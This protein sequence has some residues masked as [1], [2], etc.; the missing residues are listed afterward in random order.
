MDLV[1]A[2]QTIAQDFC[3]IEPKEPVLIHQDLN[4][5]NTLCSKDPGGSSDRWQLDALID[6]EGAVVA[7]P[8]LVW[9]TDEPWSTL[10]LLCLVVRDRWLTIMASRGGVAAASIP[11]CS[12]VE[13]VED[14]DQHLQQLLTTKYLRS[15]TPLIELLGNGRRESYCSCALQ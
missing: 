11:R 13:I 2:L 5:G 9:D 10:R 6:W 3:D 8:R 12:M 15:V 4:D 7:D 14:Y 1:L